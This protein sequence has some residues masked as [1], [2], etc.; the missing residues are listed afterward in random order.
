MSLV[1]D[2]AL[3]AATLAAAQAAQAG[4]RPTAEA[5]AAAAGTLL[6]QWMA[7]AHAAVA[8]G[9][10][11][12]GEGPAAL[13]AAWDWGPVL[14]QAALQLTQRSGNGSMGHVRRA[15]QRSVR[16]LCSALQRA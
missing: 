16:Q 15:L 9:G 2:M 7:A 5:V 6:G 10:L 8:A 13:L 11:L 4:G 1:S 12:A 14:Q 3:L